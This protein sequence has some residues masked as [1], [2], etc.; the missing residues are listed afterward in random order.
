MNT[1]LWSEVEYGID[2]ETGLRV[3]KLIEEPRQYLL[4]M[5]EWRNNLIKEIKNNAIAV[6]KFHITISYYKKLLSRDFLIKNHRMLRNRCEETLN[7]KKRG[8]P[9]F[10]S[11][12]F[13]CERHKSILSSSEGNTYYL[14]N[15]IKT[16]NYVKNTITKK[17]EWDYV[18][19]DVVEGG[20][21]TH[22]LKSDIPD[23]VMYSNLKKTKELRK[24]ALGID[25]IPS[26]TS[27]TLLT[28][29]KIKMLETLCRELP[30]VGNSKASI[31]IKVADKNYGFDFYE[32]WEGYIAYGTKNCYNPD[33]MWE[34][35]DN[36]NSSV[37][38]IPKQPIIQTY[39]KPIIREN[40][41]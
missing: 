6:P 40:D 5:F 39:K 21:H 36:A 23:A 29:Y 33:M 35:Y 2:R 15:K 14:F 30:L 4:D 1:E 3:H 22:F 25:F 20:F 10:S 9:V 26:N 24:K 31:K 34:V 32:G 41:L 13:F 17:M 12:F 11:Y 18:D 37:S 19:A 8:N 38:K 28:T 16:N 7:P 27:Q